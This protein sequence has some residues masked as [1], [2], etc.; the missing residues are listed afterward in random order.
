MSKIFMFRDVRAH[1]VKVSHAGVV[2]LPSM[3]GL[4]GLASNF[5]SRLAKAAGLGPQ[6]FSNSGV[7][8][9]FQ[10]Y[11]L[12]EGY[13]KAFKSG[14]AVT[15]AIPAVWASF[16]A[17]FAFEVK[18][19]TPAAQE[20]L[21]GM[22][23]SELAEGV[24]SSMSFCKGSLQD[25]RRPVNLDSPRLVELGAERYRAI[26][27][28]P[29]FSTVV[30]DA[31][32]LIDDMRSAGLP[33]VEG[34][35]AATLKHDARPAEYKKFFADPSRGAEAWKLAPVH[36]GYLVV[37]KVGVSQCLRPAYSG[38]QGR[39]HVASPTHTLVR[40]QLAASVKL[41]ASNSSDTGTPFWA[42]K[43]TPNSFF[44]TT[45]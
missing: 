29:S 43:A 37:D 39:S 34:L 5:A 20:L 16:T 22:D 45:A 11:A 2:G 23:L 40:L 4:T 27:M 15:E 7:L 1:S 41:D 19:E 3:T 35:L 32:F 9:A 28:L 13:K 24:L 33:L 14:K 42:L 26:A 21:D 25:V 10:D 12:H 31:A 18:A 36:D 8:F 6:D 38:V 44:S 17:H 30:V